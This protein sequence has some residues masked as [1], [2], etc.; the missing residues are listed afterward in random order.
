MGHASHNLE[1]HQ[2]QQ[3]MCSPR[4]I[5][6]QMRKYKKLKQDSKGYTLDQQ[7]APFYILHVE[8]GQT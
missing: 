1:K 4:R 7:Y 3:A 5:D 6:Q 8:R 2:H